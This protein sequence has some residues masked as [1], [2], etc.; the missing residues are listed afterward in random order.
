MY[1]VC[2]AGI[3]LWEVYAR[4]EPYLGEEGGDVILAVADLKAP[5]DK[6]PE[7]PERCPAA[8]TGLMKACWHKDPNLR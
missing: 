6:R 5:V 1:S 7:I 3:T 2:D 8:V 4:S